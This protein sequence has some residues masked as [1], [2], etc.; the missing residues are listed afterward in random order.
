M[1]TYEFIE[2]N[3]D[4]F[5]D[6]VRIGIVP[7]TVMTQYQVFCVYRS[8][9]NIT[10][11]MNRLYFTADICKVSPIVVRKAL[12]AMNTYIPKHLKQHV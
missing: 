12:R 3:L 11:K 6:F 8:A 1:K 9:D 2:S 4:A 10:A 7:T 5:K